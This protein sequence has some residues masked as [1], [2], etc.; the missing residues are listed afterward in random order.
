MYISKGVK[1]IGWLR[2][3]TFSCVFILLW[4][5]AFT[6]NMKKDIIGRKTNAGI[7]I[8]KLF[9]AI[10]TIGIH[11]EP[12]G[13]DM[14]LDYGFGLATRFCVPFFFVASSYFFWI[15]ERE[16][17]AY[18][19]RIL[20]LYVIWSLI[21]LPF[22]IP[23]LKGMPVKKILEMYLW[24]GNGHS[25]WYLWGSVVGFCIVFVLRKVMGSKQVFMVS[26]VFLLVGCIKSTW[27]PMINS[28]TNF[29][30][31]DFLGSR[32]GLFYA[33]PYI[34]LGMAVAQ[35]AVCQKGNEIGKL[36]KLL[37][38]VICLALEGSLMVFHFQTSSRILWF[39]VLPCTYYFFMLMK[40]ADIRVSDR[41]S[42]FLRKMSTLIYLEHGIF[43]IV[44]QGLDTWK[45]FIAVLIASSLLAIC[46]IEIS[47][48][49]CFHW[50]KYLY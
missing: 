3:Y 8:T 24:E 7:D 30:I 42:L 41:V 33:F 11:T 26:V 49:R 6:I 31:Q 27:A 34:A 13:F 29:E 22:D 45:Y 39:S 15:K 46:I 2:F 36:G 47:K 4:L 50:M 35:G 9:M 1:S 21:Y 38:S 43:L 5:G 44:F 23:L 40:D 12:F 18:I 19:K 20:S 28:F 10:L 37:V 14:W 25:L 17:L 32:N 16:V 48:V